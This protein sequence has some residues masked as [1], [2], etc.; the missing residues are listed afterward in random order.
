MILQRLF[1][2]VFIL[3]SFGIELCAQEPI[4]RF[5]P[6]VYLKTFTMGDPYSDGKFL[7]PPHVE[8]T[9]ENYLIDKADILAFSIKHADSSGWTLWMDFAIDRMG[10]KRLNRVFAQK[11]AGDDPL[12]SFTRLRKW[13]KALLA[14]NYGDLLSES[15]SEFTRKFKGSGSYV[16]AVAVTNTQ[17]DGNRYITIDIEESGD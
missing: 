15:E 11:K 5:D 12:A 8:T 9:F 10:S 2:A 16:L 17:E 4:G 7:T 13:M 14:E 6:I 1:I 3:L